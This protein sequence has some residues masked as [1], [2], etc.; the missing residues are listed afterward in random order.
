M[1]KYSILLIISVAAA[2]AMAQ[3]IHNNGQIIQNNGSVITTVGGGVTNDFGGQINND[4]TIIIDGNYLASNNG[5]VHNINVNDTI[6]VN[7]TWDNLNG[8][9]VGTGNGVM[10][11]NGVAQ[12][13]RVTEDTVARM[14]IAGSGDKNLGGD[15]T[16]RN[17]INF[18]ANRLF[19]SYT[20]TLMLLPGCTF[21]GPGPSNS[22][23]VD[24]PVF[25]IG[26]IA[27]QD[28]LFPVGDAGVYRPVVIKSVAGVVAPANRPV[29]S[30]EM[31]DGATSGTAGI[32]V[33]QLIDTR[34][35][36]GQYVRG[37][38]QGSQIELSYAGAEGVTDQSQLVVTQADAVAG[39][40][41]SLDQSG[42][43]GGL[44][45]GTVISEFEAGNEFFMIGESANLR[46]DL[47]VFLEGAYDTGSGTMT[48]SLFTSSY[49]SILADNYG[50][51]SAGANPYGIKMMNRY[52]VG[53][54]LGADPVDVIMLTIRDIAAPSVDIDTTYAWLMSDGTIRDFS[55]SGKQYATFSK[56][57]LNTSTNYAIVVWHRNHVP[58][59]FESTGQ[60]LTQST[61]APVGFDFTDPTNVYG[62]GYKDLLNNGAIS[63]MYIGNAEQ[64]WS[65]LEVNALDLWVVANDAQNNLPAGNLI[66]TDVNLDGRTNQTDWDKTKWAND[67]LYFST[68][69]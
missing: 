42:T 59:M 48:D 44:A 15:L 2:T 22:S 41:E 66:N 27:T 49:G 65:P 40:Y 62:V 57:S 5:K 54:S 67:Q 61:V 29:F 64:N 33:D 37:N 51:G 36:R 60:A 13:Y 1:K 9:Y 10:V 8:K 45:A 55:T 17:N 39:P 68:I 4:G 23:H 12:N 16:I 53:P 21:I 50:Y 63:G 26:G 52:N 6:Y 3:M 32:G 56:L 58:I 7:G 30:F 46:A 18:T 28:L 20:D 34:H 69:P 19:T 14:V 11:L 47:N 24:G 25:R 35:W 43:T 31:L 38:Y